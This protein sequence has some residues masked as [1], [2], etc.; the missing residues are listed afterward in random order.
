MAG[1][2]SAG[3]I[4]ASA[5]P[6]RAF[7]VGPRQSGRE[8]PR[9]VLHCPGW[10]EG[11]VRTS[12]ERAFHEP[13]PPFQHPYGDGRTGRRIAAVLATLDPDNHPIAKRNTY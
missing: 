8:A 5:I 1:N 13:V 4:E 3:R 2:S 9:S 12:V 11:S 6:V 10:D 7:D